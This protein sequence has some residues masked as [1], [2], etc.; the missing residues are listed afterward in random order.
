MTIL[1]NNAGIL[2][3]RVGFMESDDFEEVVAVNQTGPF[4]GMRAAVPAFLH[5]GAGSI[6]NIASIAAHVPAGP[7]AY[8]ATKA[9][10][11][12]RT[13]AVAHELGPHGIRANSQVLRSR[14]TAEG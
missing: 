4:L 11:R 8:C 5:N 10:L 2:G 13:L 3:Q 7:V 14:L 6:V 12:M 1:V 9:A